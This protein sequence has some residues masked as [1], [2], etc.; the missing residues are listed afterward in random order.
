MTMVATET[1]ASPTVAPE[2]LFSL[3]DRCDRC[4][5]QSYYVAQKARCA[6]LTFC[7]HHGNEH[8]ES[9]KCQGWLLVDFTSELDIQPTDIK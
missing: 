4:G 3:H 5:F 6:E 7:H 8:A 1:L 9:L 2:R